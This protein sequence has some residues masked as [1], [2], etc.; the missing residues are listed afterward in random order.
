MKGWVR[1]REERPYDLVS[2]FLI[3][4]SF[5]PPVIVSQGP[6]AWV[7]T[8][9]LSVNVRNVPEAGWLRC[10]FRTRFINNGI[11]EEDGQVWDEQGKLV[12]ISRQFAQYRRMGA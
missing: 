2:I 8:L 12:A 4:D 10:S 6:V 1:F 3:A 11:L 9:T 5:P 7:P